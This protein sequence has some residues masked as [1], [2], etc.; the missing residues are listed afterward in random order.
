MIYILPEFVRRSG[1]LD[2]IQLDIR[3]FSGMPAC[4][5]VQISWKQLNIYQCKSWLCANNFVLQ[6][7]D[8]NQ[9]LITGN[10]KYVK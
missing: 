7:Q 1:E 8:R 9:V 6:N 4:D 2:R 3:K 5:N 10:N